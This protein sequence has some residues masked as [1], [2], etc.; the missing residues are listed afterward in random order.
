MDPLAIIIR[1]MRDSLK[2]LETRMRRLERLH[3]MV[4]GGG[5]LATAVLKLG[6]CVGN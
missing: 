6:G 1:D 3:W 5:A 2:D 4:V